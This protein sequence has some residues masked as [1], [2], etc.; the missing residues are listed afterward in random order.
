MNI[1]TEQRLGILIPDGK[2]ISPEVTK[3]LG[4]KGIKII[5]EAI[6][7][8]TLHGVFENFP[9]RWTQLPSTNIIGEIAQ[10]RFFQAGFVGSDFLSEYRASLSGEPPRVEEL[11]SFCLFP[12]NVR[13]SLLVR[14]TNSEDYYYFDGEIYDDNSVDGPSDLRDRRLLTRYPELTRKFLKPHF[15][16]DNTIPVDIDT[17]IGGKEEG[18]VAAHAADATVVIV[19]SGRTMRRNGLRELAVIERD[20]QPVFVINKAA[21]QEQ[22]K[23]RLLEEFS[24]RLQNGRRSRLEQPFKTA[25]STISAI[26]TTGS[27]ALMV[28][29]AIAA[30]FITGMRRK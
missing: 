16:K 17:R 26:T 1:E 11:Q 25:A 5:G 12:E 13:V 30:P 7:N 18:M 9:G 10:G 29:A 8:G 15:P 4:N 21:I 20:I 14:D 23:E 22:G 3:Y 28:A 2:N 24:D 27:G 6:R 19:E